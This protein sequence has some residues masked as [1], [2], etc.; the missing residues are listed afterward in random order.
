[1]M[2]AAQTDPIR[3][4]ALQLLD[5]VSDDKDPNVWTARRMEPVSYTHLDVYKRQHWRRT[6]KMAAC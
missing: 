5:L 3:A 1:M 6:R 4:K 2:Q